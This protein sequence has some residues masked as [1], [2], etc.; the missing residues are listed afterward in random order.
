[1]I[2]KIQWFPSY[3]ILKNQ[4][5]NN[6]TVSYPK[7]CAFKSIMPLGLHTAHRIQTNK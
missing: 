1:M 4:N 6:S 2:F 7:V 5:L 3:I